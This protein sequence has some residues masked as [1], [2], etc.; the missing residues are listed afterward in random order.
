MKKVNTSQFK[1]EQKEFD[2]SFDHHQY[3]LLIECSETG[4]CEKWNIW[5]KENPAV[6]VKLSGANL[7]EMNLVGIDFTDADL[8]E[9]SLHK[10]DLSNATMHGANL[11]MSYLSSAN[12]SGV[13]LEDTDLC[14]VRARGVIVN[15]RTL[16][17]NCKLD[18]NTDFTGVGLDSARIDPS[19]KQ[20]LQYNIRCMAWDKWYDEG[21]WI[22]SWWKKICIKPFWWISDYGIST[23]RIINV[24]WISAFI[25]AVLYYVL[26]LIDYPG[27]ID[28]LFSIDGV[29]VPRHLIPLR[30]IYFSIVTMTTLGFG[31]MYANSNSVIGHILLMIQVVFGYL[32][33][34]ALI[35][36]L[37][38]LFTVGG[39]AAKFSDD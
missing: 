6:E 17:Y 20:L 26:G 19:L 12:F 25:F 22:Y 8:E 27:V 35:T 2:D 28:N 10:T 3:N 18:R 23:S 30:A 29:D 16:F 31:D 7:Q 9:A 34:S 14:G 39:P 1:W 11:R 36:R 37:A 32:L 5:R 4:N 13:I 15:G 33:L 38:I 24:F 21:V